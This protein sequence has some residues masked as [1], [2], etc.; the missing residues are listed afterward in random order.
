MSMPSVETTLI[1]ANQSLPTVGTLGD[2]LNDCLYDFGITLE[3]ETP[4]NDGRAVYSNAQWRI[5][6]D[7]ANAPLPAEIFH[8]TMNSVL[9]QSAF[10]EL[11]H[12]PT[13]HKAH[14]RITVQPTMQPTNPT[15]WLQNLQVAH[16]ATS[17]VV[18]AQPPVAILW[19]ASN[20]LLS[21]QQYLEL[22]D[23]PTP[24]P[25]FVNASEVKSSVPGQTSLRIDG[26]ADFIGRPI[27]FPHTDLSLEMAYAAALAFLRHA[28]ETGV[29]IPDGHNF[30]P[31]DGYVVKVSH[32]EA[33]EAQPSGHFEL[34]SVDAGTASASPSLLRAETVVLDQTRERTRSL[35]ISFLMLV[36]L[37]P[38]GIVLLFSNALLRPSSGRTGLVAMSVLAILIVIGGYTF[39]NVDT[40]DSAALATPATIATSPFTD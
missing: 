12:I 25:L 14:V 16:V 1:Y 37:P 3:P 9:S 33:T 4:Q 6:I 27:L 24:W 40:Q 20:Q 10:D 26:A 39:L 30:G 22:A 7:A 21:V 38:V 8:G 19:P 29:P 32:A 18:E 31:E 34:C 23:D 17:V 36:I 13:D 2:A 35:A 11:G 15:T 28:V 5:T